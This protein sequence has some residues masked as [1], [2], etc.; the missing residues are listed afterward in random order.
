LKRLFDALK[1]RTKMLRRIARSVAKETLWRSHCTATGIRATETEVRD[2]IVAV[3]AMLG[4]AVAQNPM[5]TRQTDGKR[6]QIEKRTTVKPTLQIHYSLLVGGAVIVGTDCAKLN[7]NAI[8]I[9]FIAVERHLLRAMIGKEE[10]GMMNETDCTEEEV[11]PGEALMTYL[12]VMRNLVVAGAEGLTVILKV[13]A[14]E[15]IPRFVAPLMAYLPTT[16]YPIQMLEFR[17]YMSVL[18]DLRS[19]VPQQCATA[20][21]LKA[22]SS[23]VHQ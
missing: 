15:E 14:A 8:P 6:L 4:L 13:R 1:K 17:L 23:L 19:S 2:L 21:A 3:H 18:Y 16:S 11:T 9:A 7:E 12:T 5:H 10:K 22:R 20:I